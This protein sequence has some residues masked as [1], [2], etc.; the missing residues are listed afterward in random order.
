MAA[1]NYPFYEMFYDS[2]ID[3]QV[4][5]MFENGDVYTNE[6][7][8]AESLEI[9]ETLCS[10]TA[11]RFGLCEANCC[12]F[13]M[14]NPLKSHKGE[15]FDLYGT[16]NHDP[17]T[18]YLLGTY[19]VTEDVA[20]A[21]RSRRDV[22]GYDELYFIVNSDVTEWYD[23]LQFPLNLYQF[24]QSFFDH[25][26]IHQ[27]TIVL[28]NDSM[29]IEKTID[30]RQLT[31]EQVL[32][33]ICEINGCFPNMHTVDDGAGNLRR[34]MEYIFLPNKEDLDALYPADDLYPDPS[35]YPQGSSD[36]IDITK[37]KYIKCEYSEYN[38]QQITQLQI[39]QHKDDIGT[40]VDIADIPITT[41]TRAV[42]DNRYIIEGNFL[43]YGSGPDYDDRMRQVAINLLQIIGQVADYIPYKVECIGNPAVR[44]GKGIRISTTSMIVYSFILKRTLRGIQ[45]LRDTYMAD[46]VVNYEEETD[47]FNTTVTQLV[48][49]TN[50]LARTASETKSLLQDF[51]NETESLIQQNADNISLCVKKGQI[52]SAIEQSSEIITIRANKFVLDSTNCKISANGT[53]TAMAIGGRAIN[54]FSD[55]IDNSN[56]MK[57]A[58][59]AIETAQ[60]AAVRAE[61]TAY[62]LQRAVD[63]INNV[64]IATINQWI[65]QMS[66]QLKELGKKGIWGPPF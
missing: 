42:T 46:G 36:I 5:I 14:R 32:S 58:N 3:K 40:I 65:L 34:E 57:K 45:S 10:E 54:Q 64:H 43:T 35:L 59:Q 8:Y 25:L 62:G 44:I 20:T 50:T 49:M 55:M 23:N 4:E 7:L 19:F 56:A 6:D 26:G 17:A 9:T 2:S 28:P 47:T 53:I 41:L 30:T 39:R 31:G 38:T 51:K 11:L 16:I 18:R 33:A 12:K 1:S 29:R 52:T 27:T 15:Y 24:R 60:I 21:D 13:T 61:S 48:G 66:D 22:T 37:S 63:I